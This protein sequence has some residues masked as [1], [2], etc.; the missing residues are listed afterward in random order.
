MIVK[1]EKVKRKVEIDK[2]APKLIQ[3]PEDKQTTN[4]SIN[5]VKSCR[6]AF[7]SKSVRFIDYDLIACLRSNFSVF[8]VWHS[9]SSLSH[10][11]SEVLLLRLLQPPA[12]TGKPPV[13]EKAVRQVKVINGNNFF[14]LLLSYV[15]LLCF[16]NQ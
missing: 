16:I 3:K 8:F 2:I 13:T 11:I 1:L 14:M 6:P 5:S 9:L 4:S 7:I 15:N 12:I 10:F